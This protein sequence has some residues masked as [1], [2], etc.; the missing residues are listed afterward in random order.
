M[1]EESRSNAASEVRSENIIGRLGAVVDRI[2][3][4]V[5]GRGPIP[6]ESQAMNMAQCAITRAT[7]SDGLATNAVLLVGEGEANERA[8]EQ[9]SGRARQGGEGMTANPN[10]GLD[11]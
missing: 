6:P 10:E 1:Q 9:V 4:G 8:G 3:R 11:E 2:E 5:E 7:V